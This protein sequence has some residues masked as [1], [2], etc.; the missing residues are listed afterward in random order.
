MATCKLVDHVEADQK[1]EAQEDYRHKMDPYETTCVRLSDRGTCLH[2]F[3]LFQI[4]YL[5]MSYILSD[6]IQD[7]YGFFFAQMSIS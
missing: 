2:K 5:A 4:C 3:I 7:V 6:L 1:T